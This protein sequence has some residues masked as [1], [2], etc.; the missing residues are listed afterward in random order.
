MT[1]T[2]GYYQQ[3]GH[4]IAAGT[5]LSILALT[6]VF[7]RIWTRVNYGQGVRADDWLIVPAAALTVGQGINLI[8]GVANKALA[9]TLV[10]PPEFAENPLATHTAQVVFTSKVTI[11]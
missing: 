8:V 4:V 5:I 3:P 10:V 6:F 1:L 7:L 9:T 11:P 2:Y